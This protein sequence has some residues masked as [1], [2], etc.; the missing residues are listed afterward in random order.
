[1]RKVFGKNIDD[2][3]D[4]LSKSGAALLASASVRSIDKWR[5][6]GL[7]S[8]KIDNFVRIK[9]ADLLDFMESYQQAP[10]QNQV[11]RPE[12]WGDG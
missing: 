3:G 5:K 7:K 11:E 2:Y 8:T 1:M 12:G 4:F 6:M 10:S 9:K